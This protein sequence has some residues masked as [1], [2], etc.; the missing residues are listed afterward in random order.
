M[1]APVP[2]PHDTGG[3]RQAA[4]TPPVVAARFILIAVEATTD[5]PRAILDFDPAKGTFP[6]WTRAI[7]RKELAETRRSPRATPV[8]PATLPQRPGEHRAGPD[9]TGDAAVE[10]A[11]PYDPDAPV[12]PEHVAVAA[13]LFQLLDENDIALVRAHVHECLTFPQIADQLGPPANADS[14]R[15]RFRRIRLRVVDAARDD[16]DLVHLIQ[17]KP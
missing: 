14:L 17:E 9:P 8:D 4:V 7:V 11:D 12:E 6:T 2:P 15:Q 1:A 13:L 3:Y 5:A 16:P 10:A